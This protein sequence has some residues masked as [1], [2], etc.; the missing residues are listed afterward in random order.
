MDADWLKLATLALSLIGSAL[1]IYNFRQARRDR[2][3]KDRLAFATTMLAMEPILDEIASLP[4][5][6]SV[7]LE[8]IDRASLAAS[9]LAIEAQLH[10]AKKDLVA[11]VPE[12]AEYII[13][14]LK[15]SRVARRA[16]MD[17][18]APVEDAITPLATYFKESFKLAKFRQ[19]APHYNMKLPGQRDPTDENWYGDD[20][21]QLLRMRWEALN[22]DA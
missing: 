1:G 14:L 10:A 7:S 19:H 9:L 8:R 13:S 11:L 22:A 17:P 16:L 21:V 2:V 3:I 20:V 18:V 15:A 5:E 12:W 4:V 6:N